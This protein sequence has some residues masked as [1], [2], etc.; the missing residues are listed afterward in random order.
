MCG[1]QNTRVEEKPHLITGER[2]ACD[3][4]CPY[5]RGHGLAKLPPCACRG[6]EPQQHLQD[7]QTAKLGRC[8]LCS[9]EYA[10]ALG[11]RG[12]IRE[13]QGLPQAPLW[14]KCKCVR[15][16][17]GE[18]KAKYGLG[19]SPETG[20]S[21]GSSVFQIFCPAEV[22]LSLPVRP[23]SEGTSNFCECLELQPGNY[24]QEIFILLSVK[25][26]ESD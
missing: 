18:S 7:L 23:L 5:S 17:R 2:E 12:S 13:T 3:L 10:I 26:I 21:S 1:N 20:S 24:L 16:K 25:S 8:L 22:P 11:T 14:V 9:R 6:D 4:I 19:Q 15:R